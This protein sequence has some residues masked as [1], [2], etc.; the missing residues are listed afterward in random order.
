MQNGLSK[1]SYQPLR[2]ITLQKSTQAF[3]KPPLRT[4]AP[5]APQMSRLNLP[6]VIR[7]ANNVK[8]ETPAE[9][10]P[11]MPSS[12]E[13]TSNESISSAWSDESMQK[14]KN[15]RFEL[16]YQPIS[17][18]ATSSS[19]RTV[20]MTCPGKE[21]RPVMDAPQPTAAAI[22]PKPEGPIVAKKPLMVP[23]QAQ[24]STMRQKFRAME[25]PKAKK[26]QSVAIPPRQTAGGSSSN[27]EL[28]V[29][30]YSIPLAEIKQLQL[31]FHVTTEVKI[32][33]CSS[34]SQFIFQFNLDDL[35][36]MMLEM[37]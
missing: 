18:T 5:M 7:N 24:M 15:Q 12:L 20:T 3:Y 37:K 16:K 29:G 33:E 23:T 31:R 11:K 36:T 21:N 14:G 9:P 22:N 25:S 26:S 10:S 4:P 8:D 13:A 28:L 19:Q 17:V 32:T 34:P 30:K 35:K 2:Q 27:P 1:P 6:T